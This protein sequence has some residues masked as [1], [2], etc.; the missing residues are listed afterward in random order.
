MSSQR[1]YR[2][3]ALDGGGIRGVIAA[4]IIQEIEKEIHQPF[5]QYF[6]MIVGTS[7]GS[8]LAAGL[9][10]GLSPAT[11]IQIYRQEGRR[12]FN[13]SWFKK[14]ISH[15]LKQPKYS[16]EGLISVLKEYLRHDQF[17]EIEF[18]QIP[19]I[20]R[21][22]LL[23]LAYDLFY[24]NTTF[25][26]SH[27]PESQKRWFNDV[28]LWEICVCSA[29]APTF[30]PPYE[31]KWQ[32][33]ERGEEWKFPHVDGGVAANNPSLAAL[34]HVVGAEKQELKDVAILSV[35]TG[36]TTEPLQYEEV[37]NWGTVKWG[38]QIA[39][40]FMGSQ[41][42]IS[43][44]I[45]RQILISANPNGYLRLQFPLNETVKRN[46]EFSAS[47]YLAKKQQ[48]NVYNGQK[49]SE[50]MDDASERNIDQLLEATESFLR[51]ENYMQVDGK[52]L[53]VKEAISKFIQDNA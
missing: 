49:I 14:N 5:N 7:T 46:T 19:Q 20:S 29:S 31:L 38:E 44:D 4:R 1:K 22:K 36:K 25:F 47:K 27:L 51:S 32:D 53:S 24:R 35:G 40:V 30:F 17:G 39:N 43:S 45:C 48:V 42:Q 28:K 8:I 3:L 18:G 13:S 10:I 33:E 9:A 21:A 37:K 41:F 11:I 50:Q 23:I 2:I 6:D 26:I 52:H 16:N 12:I 34:S 15:W